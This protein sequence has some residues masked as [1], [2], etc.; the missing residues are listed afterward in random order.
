MVLQECGFGSHAGNYAYVT[1][2]F[3]GKP[4]FCFLSKRSDLLGAP[5]F[6]RFRDVN[7]RSWPVRSWVILESFIGL[8]RQPRNLLANSEAFEGDRL[9]LTRL[10]TVHVLVG[11]NSVFLRLWSYG[12]RTYFIV[13]NNVQPSITFTT[14]PRLVNDMRRLWYLKLRE[15]FRGTRS[16]FTELEQAR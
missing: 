1:T 4:V 7:V 12:A 5:A 15:A 14:R 2:R 16:V 13:I 3:G 6:R 11:R 9:T 8:G 10:A